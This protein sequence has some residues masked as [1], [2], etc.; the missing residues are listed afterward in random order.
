MRDHIL[1]PVLCLAILCGCA[2]A[3]A[4]ASLAPTGA[5]PATQA[6]GAATAAE[7]TAA[8]SPAATQ[9]PYPGPNPRLA[10]FSY[11]GDRL[12][13]QVIELGSEEA[14]ATVPVDDSW[15]QA[16]SPDGRKLFNYSLLSR[17]GVI[18]D[19]E[20]GE[21]RAIDFSAQVGEEDNLVQVIW[22]PS[23]QWLSFT[24]NHSTT[25]FLWV[26]SLET[27]ALTFIDETAETVNGSSRED[28]ISYIRYEQGSPRITYNLATGQKTVWR[29]PNFETLTAFFTH[30]G[31]APDITS[32]SC[33]ICLLPELGMQVRDYTSQNRAAGRYDYHI[34]DTDTTQLLAH[35]ATFRTERDMLVE[36][37]LY[38]V[39]LLPL[40]ERGDYLLFVE[41]QTG[42]TSED[43]QLNFYS[44]W[45]P[46]A[47]MPF[48]VEEGEP[49]NTLPGVIPMA[50]SPDG[51][52]FVGFRLMNPEP[53]VFL[54]EGAVIVDL[55]TAEI[56][57]EYPMSAE[58]VYFSPPNEVLG[59][60]LVWP[61]E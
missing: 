61:G 53:F 32:T 38:V 51:A 52:S 3:P 16:L 41:E 44:A 35:V 2:S 4:E 31:I 18:Y 19:L 49:A 37:L 25:T 1:L 23:Q 48:T 39:K 47:E 29:N 20:S 14:V 12:V 40:R 27:G 6:A 36:H 26:Y 34:V 15:K 9:L 43:V 55:A 56:L 30:D 13:I 17:R 28:I 54:V 10:I 21:S 45:N 7:P 59:A 24:V 5:P 60:G 42:S 8:P 11:E 57:Y 33:E 46:P 22:A 58:F 50:V